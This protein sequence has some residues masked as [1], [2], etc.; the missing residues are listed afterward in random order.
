[1]LN[2]LDWQEHDSCTGYAAGEETTAIS[3]YRFTVPQSALLWL[4]SK[5]LSF[6][7]KTPS[8]YEA[9]VFFL[10]SEM[11]GDGWIHLVEGISLVKS[12]EF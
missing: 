4:K 3:S 8:I 12:I 1:M 9:G 7:L 10:I 6:V 5:Q 2:I 11:H